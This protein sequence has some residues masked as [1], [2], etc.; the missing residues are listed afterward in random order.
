MWEECM[1]HMWMFRLTRG[2]T[3]FSRVCSW[4]EWEDGVQHTLKKS[5]KICAFAFFFTEHNES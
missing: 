2:L 1:Q 3:R 4:R 5:V